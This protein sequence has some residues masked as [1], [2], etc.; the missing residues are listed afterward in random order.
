MTGLFQEMKRRNVFRVAIAYIAASWLV[1]QVLDLVVENVEAPPWVMKFLLAVA[2]IGFPLA[3]VF[4]WAYELT[5]EGM[6]REKEVDRTESITHQTGRRLDRVIMLVLVGAVAYFIWERQNVNSEVPPSATADVVVESAPVAAD[7]Q[8]VVET[9]TVRRSI[10]VLPFVNM[11]SDNEQE[12]FADGLTEEILNSLAKTPDLLVAARTSSFGFKGSTESVPVIAAALGVDH[13]LEGSVRRGGE[14]LR[15][16]AQLIRASDGFHLWSETF[17]RT[18]EDIIAIQEE[19]AVQIATALETAMDPEALEEMMKA[20][21][22][23]VA[24]YESFLNG[25]GANQAQGESGDPYELLKVRESWERAVELDP[26]FSEAL[27][28]LSLFWTLQMATNQISAGITDLSFDEMQTKRDDLLN[29]AIRHEQD[30]VTRLRYEGSKALNAHDYRR[31]VR[32]FSEYRERRPN[33]ID[34]N[35]GGLLFAQSVLGLRAEQTALIREVYEQTE[36]TRPLANN[37]SQY[38]R[39]PEDADLMRLIGHDA[40]EKFSNDASLMYQVHR[41]LLW[42]GDIDGASRLIPAIVSSNLPET[43]SYLVKLRQACAEQRLSDAVKLHNS[44][45]EK[46]GDDVSIAWLSNKIIGDDEAAH[47]LLTDIDEQDNFEVMADYLNYTH[48]DPSLYPNMM[49]HLAGQ[50]EEDRQL[51]EIPYRCGR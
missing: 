12:Y 19:I 17:D 22:S 33:D 10:A 23:S 3:L 35:V 25:Q 16:T 49:S 2:A 13:V 48:F 9:E 26:E 6:K 43:S 41:L 34:R 38:L 20:G 5:P 8:E 28:R 40:A 39:T 7:T 4:S 15:I 42:A 14:T 27:A 44:G 29:R 32:L 31:A 30:E 51:I 46:F 37:F 21:T 11:S 45:M 47:A 50:L 36:L 18:M 24:A 1:L